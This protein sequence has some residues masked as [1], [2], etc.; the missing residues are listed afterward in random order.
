LENVF[1]LIIVIG[2]AIFIVLPFFKKRFEE[3]PPETDSQNPIEEKIKSLNSEKESLYSALKELDFDYSMGKLS[4]EDYG[5]LERKY[6]AQ[7]VF[8][9]REIDNIRGKSD[10][11]NLDEEIEKEIRVIREAKLT[12]DKEIEREILKSR[13]SRVLET[14]SSICSV[15]GNE[16]KSDDRFCSKCGASLN[17]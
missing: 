15:C 3:I 4:K 13:K 11:A 14:S 10:I 16:Y 2:A 5:E 1:V 6:K 8:V 9:L 17:A 12:D 7:A